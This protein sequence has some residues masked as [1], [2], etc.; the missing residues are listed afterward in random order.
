M[1]RL[2]WLK[3]CAGVF[4]ATGVL[5][6]GAAAQPDSANAVPE[7][8]AEDI[9]GFTSPSGVGNPGDRSFV[10]END[11]R[12]GK[13]SGVYNALDTK[14]EFGRTLDKNTWVGGSFFG[15][16][17]HSRDV[18]GLDNVNHIDFDGM[19]FELEH[20]ILRRSAGN[21][22]AISLSVEPRWSRVDGVAGERSNSFGGSFKLFADAVIIPDKLFW[23]ANLQWTPQTAQD[24]MSRS[25]WI[26]SSSTLAS[27]ALTAQLSDKIFLGIETRYLSAFE[28]AWFN[29]N[30]GNALYI[31]PTMLWRVT[32]KISINATLQP[33]I[34]GH[35]VG[36][37]DP[38]LDLDNFERRQ[39]RAKLAVAF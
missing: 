33:Q 29:Q 5:A 23:G 4:L 9:F 28:G 14:Y 16:Y 34:A 37:P 1:L 36:S 22:F 21:P 15:S 25:S 13:R 11:G 3:L 10:N 27:M 7:V 31:G 20:R 26:N 30:L 18:S 39:Y 2:R 6:N 32:D 12:S 38:R 35:A 8:P 17:N 19:S 24:P